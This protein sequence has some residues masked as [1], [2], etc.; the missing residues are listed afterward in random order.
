LAWLRSSAVVVPDRPAI[1]TVEGPGAADCLQGLFTN[2]VIKPGPAT[3]RY[4]AFLTPKGAIIVD[5]WLARPDGAWYLVVD[6]LGRQPTAELLRRQLP[7]RLAKVTDR[8]DDLAALWLLGR[9][10]LLRTLG[11]LPPP[12]RAA[13]PDDGAGFRLIAAGPPT[14]P[15]AGLVVAA[16]GS[17]GSA[18]DALT[19]AGAVPGAVTDL[20]IS[21][22]MAGAPTLGEEIDDR[23]FPQE[24]DFDRLEAVSYSKGCYVGQE[25]VA[26]IHFRGHPNWLLRGV[27]AE[28]GWIPTESVLADGKPVA[29]MGTLLLLE[30]RA[31]MGLAVVRREIAPGSTL[32]GADPVRVVALP[33][34]A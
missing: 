5:G 18:L 29:R 33:F 6:A 4:G 20:R 30:D 27:R 31:L 32:P 9:P 12:G 2:D 25:T 8:S 16:A 24:A 13:S 21:R 15:F 14:A 3:L 23:T 1:F 22:V 7:P 19:G 11:P 34:D 17:Q 28:P 26:R 10:P